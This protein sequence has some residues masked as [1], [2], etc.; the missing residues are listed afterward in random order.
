[1]YSKWDALVSDAC[2]FVIFLKTQNQ[3]FRYSP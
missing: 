2:Y 1:M 3:N